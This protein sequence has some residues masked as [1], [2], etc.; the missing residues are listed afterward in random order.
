MQSWS[1]NQHQDVCSWLQTSPYTLE[2]IINRVF[3]A[4]IRF[5]KNKEELGGPNLSIH[6]LLINRGGGYYREIS[7][8]GL[9]VLTALSLG[10]Y[11]LSRTDRYIKAKVWDF[12]VTTKKTRLISYFL[13]G[14]FI[15]D[16]SL[17]SI[18]TN[19]WSADT[20]KNTKLYTWARDTV[21]CHWSMDTL[22]DSCQLTI[23]WVSIRMST[24][25]FNTDCICLGHLASNANN[26]SINVLKRM[27]HRSRL[28]VPVRRTHK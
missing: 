15:M 7:D 23:I 25:K 5:W 1:Y 6:I 4:I 11:C 10:Q 24:I 20:L 18:K 28:S 12:P 16:L 22:F 27:G 26:Q 8:L 3:R 2:T 14:L 13:D 19:N 21:R 17:R 9:D